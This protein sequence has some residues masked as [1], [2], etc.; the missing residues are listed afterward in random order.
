[1]GTNFYRIPTAEE[2]KR[3]KGV[4]KEHVENMDMS[5]PV[6]E[7]GFRTIEDPNAENEWDN[8]RSPWDIFTNEVSIH[9]G[10]RSAGWLF[11]WNFNNNK[12]YS[13]KEELLAFIRSGLVVDEYGTEIDVEEF[14][15]MA[16]E[17]GQ[18]DG[19]FVGEDYYKAQ[20]DDK[21]KSR[22]PYM[23]GPEYF[24]ELIDGLRVSTS[25]DFC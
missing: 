1:M 24:D 3:R 15:D 2:M 21:G 5:A 7:S 20:F 12:F 16:L 6:I 8:L 17:W 25:S 11:C 4:L 23:S 13:N 14:I 19:W 22:P 18:P 9:L 10:K